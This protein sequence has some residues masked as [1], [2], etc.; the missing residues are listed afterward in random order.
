MHQ[1]TTI[2][3]YICNVRLF[4]QSFVNDMCYSF[5]GKVSCQLVDYV[6]V[7]CELAYTVL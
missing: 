5:L 4:Y 2:T 3:L 7:L 1:A 6:K